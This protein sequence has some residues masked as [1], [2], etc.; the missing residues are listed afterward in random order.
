[1]RD[2]LQLLDMRELRERSECVIYC[3]HW[4]CANCVSARDA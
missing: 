2:L 3:N 4:M 1:M